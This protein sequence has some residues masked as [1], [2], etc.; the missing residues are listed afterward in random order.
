VFAVL[1]AYAYYA[2]FAELWRGKSNGQSD[3]FAGTNMVT[4]QPIENAVSAPGIRAK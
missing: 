3:I 2:A 1:A 4:S